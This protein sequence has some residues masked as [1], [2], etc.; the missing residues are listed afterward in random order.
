MEQDLVED[1]VDIVITNYYYQ[2]KLIFV[3]TKNQQNGNFLRKSAQ[4]IE[5]QGRGQGE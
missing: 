4:R 1:L 5:E 2:R 3:N